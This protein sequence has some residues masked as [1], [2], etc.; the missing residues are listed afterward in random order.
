MKIS[1]VDFWC[2]LVSAG[3]S[4]PVAIYHAGHSRIVDRRFVLEAEEKGAA[5]ATAAD[6]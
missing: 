1:H 5:A 3:E 2:R 4:P 6:V